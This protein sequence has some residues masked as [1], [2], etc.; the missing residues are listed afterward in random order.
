MHS[1]VAPSIDLAARESGEPDQ[2]LASRYADQR[3]DE[4]TGQEGY[5]ILMSKGLDLAFNA[6]DVLIDA[7]AEFAIEQGLTT[8]GGWEV[9][10]DDWTSIPWCSEDE[11]QAWYA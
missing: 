3:W 10:L 9:Y 4:D 2:W 11:M 1:W 7:I 8:N 5:D 6:S